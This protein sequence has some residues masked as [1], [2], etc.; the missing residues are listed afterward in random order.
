MAEE[1]KAAIATCKS[2]KLGVPDPS[3]T[4]ISKLAAMTSSLDDLLDSLPA[5]CALHDYA[6]LLSPLNDGPE[7]KEIFLRY[8]RLVE[9]EGKKTFV[10]QA[11]TRQ[12]F[13]LLVRKALALLQAHGVGRGHRVLHNFSANRLEDLVFRAAAVL[14]GFVPVTVN[15]QADS[16]DQVLYKLMVTEA[17]AV[18]YD[19][20][21][22]ALDALREKEREGAVRM[23]PLSALHAAEPL[24]DLLQWIEARANELPTGGDTRCIIFTSG[25]TGRPKGQCRQFV[26]PLRCP[27]FTLMTMPCCLQG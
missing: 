5:E 7:G 8:Y 15:W 26:L 21:S 9:Q 22:V 4:L 1:L 12:S 10:A 20:E 13:L 27:S 2:R 24:D 16:D 19:D 3:S 23:L 25:T 6:V 17:V 18:L 11:V 14:L